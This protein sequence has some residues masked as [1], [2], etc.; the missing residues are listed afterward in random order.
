MKSHVDCFRQA[1]PKD[2][3]NKLREWARE[4][5]HFHLAVRNVLA[6]IEVPIN[7]AGTCLDNGSAEGY[8]TSRPQPHSGFITTVQNCGGLTPHVFAIPA[9]QGEEARRIVDSRPYGKEGK[10][11]EASDISNGA[12]GTACRGSAPKR[13]ALSSSASEYS[14]S[15]ENR[16][17]RPNAVRF[18]AFQEIMIKRNLP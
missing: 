13:P 17:A 4:S 11:S 18:T 1:A 15:G 12:A 5:E 8:P 14:A 7:N 6:I 10:R 9:V 2:S 16:G 3:V